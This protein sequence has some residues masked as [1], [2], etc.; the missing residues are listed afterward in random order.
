MSIGTALALSPSS[1]ARPLDA[2]ASIWDEK[3]GDP[4]PSELEEEDEEEELEEQAQQEITLRV[5]FFFDGTGDNDSNALRGAQCRAKQLGYDAADEQSL[6]DYC[7][8]YQMDPMSSYARERTNIA[9]LHDLYGDDLTRK[10]ADTDQQAELRVY[11]EGVGTRTDQQDHQFP[12]MALGNGDTGVIAKVVLGADRLSKS[13]KSFLELNPLKKVAC[14]EVDVFGFS[15]GAAAARHFVNDLRKGPSS[16][17]AEAILKSEVLLA[18]QFTWR[19]GL[20]IQVNLV[21]VENVRSIRT[22]QT[23]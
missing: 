15:R 10:L 19:F 14:I 20:D 5:G 11:I 12:D 2:R 6:L 1:R 3:T 22:N 4:K 23:W 8:P 7:P 17:L 13:L 16:L 9:R 21:G 18:D